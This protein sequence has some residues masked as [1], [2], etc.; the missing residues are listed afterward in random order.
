MNKEDDIESVYRKV[1]KEIEDAA[2]NTIGKTTFKAHMKRKESEEIKTLKNQKKELKK[3]IN[4]EKSEEKKK[5]LIEKHKILQE[6]TRE[7]LAKD[8]TEEIRRKLEKIVKDTT[9]KSFWD[10]KRKM[11]RNPA[12]TEMIIKDAN[13][14]RQY[15]P[16][17]IKEAHAEYYESL[18]KWKE[19]PYHPYHQEIQ[20]KMIQYTNDRAHENTYYNAQPNIVEIAKIIHDKKNGKSAPDF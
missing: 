18:Y 13:G 3:E 4:A 16:E 8:K 12:H 10:I 15:A 20:Q 14:Q 5:I 7:A 2:R 17:A 19:F 6:K 1:F 11:S 9:G